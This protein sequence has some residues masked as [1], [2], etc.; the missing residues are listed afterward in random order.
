[1][2]VLV[3][4]ASGFVGANLVSYLKERDYYI[5]TI[6]FRNNKWK[7]EIPP[8]Y[9]A[10]LHLAGKAHAIEK[11]ANSREYFYVNTELT[12]QVFD[13]F[14]KGPGRDFVYFSSVKA[15]ADNV[16]G[17]LVE[18]VLPNPKTVYGQSK[19]KAEEIIL[20]QKLP[21]GKR[22]FIFRPCMIHGPGNKGNLNLLF[23][24]VRS[25]WP[26]PLAAF[27]NR[28]SFL[29]VKN[30]LFIVNKILSESDIPG[31]V[32]NLSDDEALSTNEVIKLIGDCIGVHPMLLKVPPIIIWTIAK[33]GDTLR[34]KLNSERLKKM[35]ESYIVSNRKI[36]EALNIKSLPV[37]SREGLRETIHSFSNSFIVR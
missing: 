19:L 28:R 36:V 35:T 27:E 25:K 33:S 32:Y 26:Y 37:T 17:E 12:R 7:A 21:E 4:G 13:M 2:N 10:I 5:N 24:F 1:M 29:S 31:G 11:V 16:S 20:S 22:V 8:S 14:I 9:D 34:L 6:D 15:I 23:R 18:D 30:L 3:S